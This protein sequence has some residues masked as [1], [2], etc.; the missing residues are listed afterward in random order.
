MQG[1]GAE[2][3]ALALEISRIRNSAENRLSYSFFS[4][5]GGSDTHLTATPEPLV[6]I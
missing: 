2:K 6:A 5:L 3:K 1:E 4:L